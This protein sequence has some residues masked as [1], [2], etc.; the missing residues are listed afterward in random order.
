[1]PVQPIKC[2][3]HANPNVSRL[4]SNHGWSD[5]SD[6]DNNYVF[7]TVKFDIIHTVRLNMIFLTHETVHRIWN[8]NY[9][10]K[11]FFLNEGVAM[12]YS[13]LKI[14]NVNYINQKTIR[15]QLLGFV[16]ANPF[17]DIS[18]L[19]VDENFFWDNPNVSYAYAG[20]FCDFLITQYGLDSFK[21]IYTLC[22]GID[23]FE[24]IY[25]KSL[26]TII[27]E[28]KKWIENSSVI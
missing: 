26:G 24:H 1:M 16:K 28:F 4:F 19:I 8:S 18:R 9:T 6:Y 21:K 3:I 2:Y 20:Y 15:Q 7:G 11:N 23:S 22:E 13:V 5:C 12:Y 25:G 14:L 27:T 17:Y 10:A